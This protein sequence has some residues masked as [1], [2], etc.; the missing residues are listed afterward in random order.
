MEL[1]WGRDT[2]NFQNQD[3][4][5]KDFALHDRFSQTHDH[6]DA[7]NLAYIQEVKRAPKSA[8]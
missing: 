4:S 3:I 5:G 7:T 2:H 8:H 1:V 6:R